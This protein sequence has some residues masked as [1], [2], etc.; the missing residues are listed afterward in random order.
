MIDKI[1]DAINEDG[2]IQAIQFGSTLPGSSPYVCVKGEKG[3]GGRY[4]RFIVH[5][6]VGNQNSLED[7]LRYIISF[8]RN[9]GFTSRTGSYN[10]LGEMIEYTDV[11]PVSD[12]NTISMEA[13]FL[14]PTKTF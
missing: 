11:M 8:A 10:E 7:N 9:K 3:I 14:M 12:D 4:V 6:V 1:V 13:L 5:D 2:H